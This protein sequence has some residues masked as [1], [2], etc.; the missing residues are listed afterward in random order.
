[1]GQLIGNLRALGDR[2]LFSAISLAHDL[3]QE[4][5]GQ[6]PCVNQD[7]NGD[8]SDIAGQLFGQVTTQIRRVGDLLGQ[9][10]TNL[11]FGISGELFNDLNRQITF[12][13]TQMLLIQLGQNFTQHLHAAAA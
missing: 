6:H 8:L 10:D 5:F 4:L 2:F 3:D 1:M 13:D 9:G 11:D 7:G 12:L